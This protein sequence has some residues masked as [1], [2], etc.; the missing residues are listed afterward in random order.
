MSGQTWTPAPR[1][2]AFPL[3]PMT[4]GM[5]LGRAFAALR[6][7]PRV[8]FGFAVLLEFVITVIMAGVML[9]VA[10]FIAARISSVPSS[11]PDF[12]PILIGSTALGG[13]AVVVMA[14]AAVAFTAVIQGLVAADVSYAAVGRRA[15]LKLLWQRVRPA[16]WRLFGY[17]LLQGVAVMLWVAIVLGAVVGV[18]AALGPDDGAAIALSVAVGLLLVLGSVPLFVWLSTKL[19]V[20]PA[21]LV[22]E[23]ASLRTALVRSWRLIRGRFWFA[24]GVM[25][26]IGLIMNIAVQVVAFPATLISG[27]LGG[28]LVPTGSEEPSAIITMIAANALPQVLVLAVQAIALVVQ[29]TG[30]TLIYVDSRMRYEG[31]DQTLIRYVERSAQGAADQELGDPWEVDASRAVSKNPPP[32]QRPAYPASPFPYPSGATGY[33]ATGYGQ[34]TYAPPPYG[35]PTYAQPPYAPRPGYPPPPAPSPDRPAPD[36]QRDADAPPPDPR[37]WAPPGGDA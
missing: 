21:V 10:W 5:V 17:S 1:K 25:F 11:S 2:G 34:P 6:H 26:V 8:L 7:N 24:F 3:H 28:I 14:L 23:R 32:P 22:L 36:P 16:F 27:V 19:L 13:L 18:L 37:R 9:L 15:S 29:G 30:A 33:R 20:V 12:W 35:Q 4:F 31:L